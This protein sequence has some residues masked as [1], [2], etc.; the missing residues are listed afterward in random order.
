MRCVFIGENYQESCEVE[1]LSSEVYWRK[2]S[3][4][5]TNFQGKTNVS[6]LS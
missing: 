4:G 1:L 6:G 3:A 2:W 5:R